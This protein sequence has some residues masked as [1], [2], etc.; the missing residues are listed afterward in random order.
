MTSRK[1]VITGIG[2]VS[3]LGSTTDEL[4][5]AITKGDCGI[6]A[7]KAFDPAG[8]DCK[9][10]GEV[11]AFKIQK[12]LPKFHRKA[13]KLMC[14]DI[15]LSVLAAEEA[16]KNSGLITKG[17]DADNI[18]VNS[19]RFAINI[20]AGVICCDL[21]E[22]AP[23]VSKCSTDEEFD[24]KKWGTDGIPAITPL[25]L[26]KYLPNMPACHIAI[27]HDIQGPNNS[28]VCA[29]AGAHLAITEAASVIERD[30]ADIALAGG[31]DAKVNPIMMLR[32]CL[33][34]RVTS[35][36][37]DDPRSAVRPFDADAKGSVFGEGSGMLVLEEIEHAKARGA[38]IR[39]ELAGTGSSN[40]ISKAYEHLEADGQGVQYAI[41][42]A[43]EDAGIKPEDIDLIIPHG[44]GILQDDL[45]EA[46]GIQNALGDAA[47]TIP[48]W[49]T[50][51]MLSTT[52]AA[53]GAIDV[54]LAIKA[55]ETG[56]IGP[57]KNIENK[58]P[59]CELNISTE[60]QQ[61]N[62]TYVLCCSYSFGGNTTALI[63]KK[64]NG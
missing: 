39:A 62:I 44:T 32:Q 23:A 57:A 38:T 18:N 54:A 2:T 30:S 42:N 61:K 21:E 9:L 55:I 43:L 51:S 63:I 19:E 27:I 60:P 56:T 48:T 64:Y 17:I 8:F 20:G 24:T 36:N 22:I 26:L 47:G 15:Q 50:K 37:N 35:Q 46:K 28:I 12:H 34:K 40:N 1:V 7:T 29:E 25:W 49:P 16:I 3:P 13:A 45:A 6:E 31:C 5:Q 14:R 41:E 33:V 59:G 4:W 52:G 10:A 11:P 53:S 58:A